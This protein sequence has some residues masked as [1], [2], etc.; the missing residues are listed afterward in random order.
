MVRRNRRVCRSARTG[1]VAVGRDGKSIQ[2][3]PIILIREVTG[4]GL[5]GAE[6]GA[7]GS[8]PTWSCCSDHHAGLGYFPLGQDITLINPNTNSFFPRRLLHDRRQRADDKQFSRRLTNGAGSIPWRETTRDLTSLRVAAFVGPRSSEIVKGQ[9]AAVNEIGVTRDLEAGPGSTIVV[10]VVVNLRPQGQLRSLQFRVEVG[11][12][13]G[14]APLIPERLRALSI[15]TNDLIPVVTSS[16]SGGPA[17]FSATAY[18]NVF[19][20][21]RGL[22]IAFIGANSGLSVKNFA[23]V[24]MLAVPIPAGA[25]L[26]DRTRLDVIAPSGTSD[27]VEAKSSLPHAFARSSLRP[28][29][30]SR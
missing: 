9:P 26:G 4:A 5:T 17:S 19:N 6:P 14:S 21:Y 29:A 16:E 20:E 8:P 30:T 24:A 13:S 23:V 25:K 18:T 3:R 10:P 1:W 27:G 2:R 22:A 12:T 7:T 11:P 28:P 15:S